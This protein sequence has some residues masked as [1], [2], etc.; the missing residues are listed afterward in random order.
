MTWLLASPE[1]FA[2]PDPEHGDVCGHEAPPGIAPRCRICER[3]STTPQVSDSAAR[4]A[5]DEDLAV[6]DGFPRWW[7]AHVIALV[8]P[9]KRVAAD[10]LVP[11]RD[12]VLDRDLQVGIGA[13]RATG[14]GQH[15]SRVR[16]ETPNSANAAWGEVRGDRSLPQSRTRGTLRPAL[17]ELDTSAPVGLRLHKVGLHAGE[18]SFVLPRV[19]QTG[20]DIVT[21]FVSGPV[22]STGYQARPDGPFCLLSSGAVDALHGWMLRCSG[23]RGNK[24]LRGG[25]PGDASP[26]SV[27]RGWTGRPRRQCLRYPARNARTPASA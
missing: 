22:T 3:T 20:V 17:I 24:P 23:V 25:L 18:T 27:T 16:P 9:S 12:H 26:S 13:R 19:P 8:G 21:A 4:E 2:H 5:E 1:R 11:L 6:C 14:P 10:D 7:Q 15:Q